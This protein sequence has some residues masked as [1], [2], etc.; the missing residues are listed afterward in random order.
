MNQN[1]INMKSNKEI[2][3]LLKVNESIR[4]V[5][6]ISQKW[7]MGLIIYFFIRLLT[8]GRSYK[9]KSVFDEGYYER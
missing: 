8:D 3:Y 1:I 9:F 2:H 5:L 6:T 7:L 4:K